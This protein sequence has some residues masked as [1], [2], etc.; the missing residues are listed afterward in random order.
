MKLALRNVV[1]AAVQAVQRGSR[2]Q[3][4]CRLH[5]DAVKVGKASWI[6]IEANVQPVLAPLALRSHCRHLAG[7][8]SSSLGR[9]A[10]IMHAAAL[11][12]GCSQSRKIDLA[13]QPVRATDR[14]AAADSCSS[15]ITHSVS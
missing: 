9:C 2:V 5:C 15:E 10:A 3:P 1:K 6:S 13:Q 11:K 7:P 12:L 8:S 4:H 14:R